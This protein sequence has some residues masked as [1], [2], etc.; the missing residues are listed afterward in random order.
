MLRAYHISS[1]LGIIPML[2]A[3]VVVYV[4]R[5]GVLQATV[6]SSMLVGTRINTVTV[7][8]FCDIMPNGH[9]Y[10]K[11]MYLNYRKSV[12]GMLVCTNRKSSHTYDW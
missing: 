1:Q 7:I 12:S 4:A 6:E 8:I 10:G 3:Q 9:M 2:M 5:S 11:Y